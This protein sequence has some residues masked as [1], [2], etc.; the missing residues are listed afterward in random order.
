[1][2]CTHWKEVVTRGAV[3]GLSGCAGFYT[4]NVGADDAELSPVS[5]GRGGEAGGPSL[6]PELTADASPDAA[7]V[8]SGTES[9]DE[10]SDAESVPTATAD[11]NDGAPP[12][13]NGSAVP[14]C[15]ALGF[16]LQDNLA[17]CPDGGPVY[18]LLLPFPIESGGSYTL[19]FTLVGALGPANVFGLDDACQAPE[20]LG[21][22][23]FNGSP[24]LPLCVQPQGTFS[25][26]GLAFGMPLNTTLT[27][28]ITLCSGCIGGEIDAGAQ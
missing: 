6:A 13:V 3:A 16:A 2:W 27:G 15:G 12:S 17:S 24:L 19:L 25:A 7:A 22:Q 18:E 21:T 14:Y 4:L 9:G 26:V 8:P 10:S 28:A 20:F 23:T 5:L 1:M 11:A